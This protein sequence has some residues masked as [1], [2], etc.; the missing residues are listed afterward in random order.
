MSSRGRRRC[1]AHHSHHLERAAH[2]SRLIEQ[3]QPGAHRTT[4]RRSR[5][6]S[7]V[8]G[9]G[10]AETD[11]DNRPKNTE[12]SVCRLD[13]HRAVRRGTGHDRHDQ[14]QNHQRPD[15]GAAGYPAVGEYQ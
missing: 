14:R 1:L 9:R 4:N 7:Y 13:C 10:F 11:P 15:N 2:N 3:V 8:Q 5:R 12:R 6:G